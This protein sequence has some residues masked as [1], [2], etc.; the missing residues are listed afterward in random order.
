MPLFVE[1]VRP[2]W[3]ISRDGPRDF[4]GGE[5]WG[6]LSVGARV[7]EWAL[8]D[9]DSVTVRHPGCRGILAALAGQPSEPQRYRVCTVKAPAAHG[10]ERTWW[11]C[12]GC[13]RRCGLLFLIVGRDRL[14]CRRCCRL[15]Y[16]SQYRPR[17]VGS[18][19]RG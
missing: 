9:D 15:V 16:R 8:N 3:R 18:R 13:G 12:P 17:G 6:R 11:A 2:A 14:G 10:G 19:R 5:F 7:V 1:Y 4:S